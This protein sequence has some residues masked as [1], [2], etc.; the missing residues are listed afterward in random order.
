MT[1]PTLPEGE[2][3]VLRVHPH[4][5]TVLRPTLVLALIVAALIVVMVFLPASADKP[6]VRLAVGGLAVLAAIIFWGIPL[7]RWRT[8]SYELT[9][10]RLRLRSGILTRT[11]RDFPLSRISDVS[12][13]QGVLDRVL[14]SG[15][16][17]IESAGEHG[18]LVLTEIPQVQRVQAELFQL[19]EIEQSPRGR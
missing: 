18:E 16:L 11:G 10:R 19:I 3:P 2:Y 7:L 8:T 12:F 15:R 17:V 14:G 4:W 6:V 9:S 5:K 1:G 13:S